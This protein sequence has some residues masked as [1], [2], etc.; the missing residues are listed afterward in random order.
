MSRLKAFESIHPRDITA[1]YLYHGINKTGFLGVKKKRSG[2]EAYIR[3]RGRF[4]KVYCGHGKTAEEA[5]MKY[6]EM[7]IRL[8]GSDAV[9][10]F[11]S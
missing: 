3:V 10:N 11:R 6:D 1:W 7:A 4:K 5:A 2:Y 9:T 8:F